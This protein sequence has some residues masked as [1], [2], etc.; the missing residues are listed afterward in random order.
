M[1]L[2]FFIPSKIHRFHLPNSQ[3]AAVRNC[4]V[5]KGLSASGRR[6]SSHQYG[7]HFPVSFL[8]PSCARC[9][10]FFLSVPSSFTPC[11]THVLSLDSTNSSHTFCNFAGNREILI[12]GRARY[13][14]H[15][16][17][18]YPI[19]KRTKKINHM[20]PRSKNSSIKFHPFSIFT[21]SN[22]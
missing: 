17:C 2:F 10:P 14:R 19:Q 22:F 9:S 18:I 13:L 21:R 1:Y 5:L 16:V 6:C 4:Q 12:H 20:W 15:T 8:S 3:F 11:L 7:C